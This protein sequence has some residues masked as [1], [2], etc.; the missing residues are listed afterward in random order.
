M[1]HKWDHC[2][3]QHNRSPLTSLLH[4]G[5][6][7]HD[8]IPLHQHTRLCPLGGFGQSSSLWLLS[9][10]ACNNSRNNSTAAMVNSIDLSH[11]RLKCVPSTCHRLFIE[12][13]FSAQG[14]VS[15]LDFSS[16]CPPSPQFSM[17]KVNNWAA[18]PRQRLQQA[19]HLQPFV[20]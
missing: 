16:C 14:L 19:R 10:T 17:Q 8:H 7:Q 12:V 3:L 1:D 13:W 6:G 20:W 15:S 9:H 4:L 5:E 11:A 2:L 18:Q